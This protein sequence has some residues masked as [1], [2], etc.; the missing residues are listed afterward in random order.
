MFEN[1]HNKIVTV[2]TSK[3]VIT[4]WEVDENG[5]STG[6]TWARGRGGQ[7]R[8]MEDWNLQT[9]RIE[10]RPEN[11]RRWEHTMKYSQKWKAREG[12]LIF[13]EEVYRT[14]KKKRVFH[15]QISVS[16]RTLRSSLNTLQRMGRKPKVDFKDCR[17]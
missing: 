16:T 4:A 5:L 14:K 10:R 13:Q 7:E 17:N 3:N 8:W 9:Y 15:M 11:W 1:L 2:M 6:G 12:R